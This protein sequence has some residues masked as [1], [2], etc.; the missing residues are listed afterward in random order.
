LNTAYIGLGS[1]MGDRSYFLN[2][3]IK[4]L[5]SNERISVI[6]TS[7]IYETAPVG[8]L[9]QE[10]FL[11]MVIKVSTILKPIELLEV[12]Q[13]VEKDLGR[14]RDIRWGPRTID[15]DILMYNNENIETEKLIIPHPRM[16]ERAFVLVPLMEIDD[17][18]E[19]PYTKMPISLFIKELQDREEV[20]IWKRKSGEGV[21]ELFEN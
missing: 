6:A 18:I 5:D 9:E 1:N 12:N 20:Q 14:K 7:S 8:Y 3:A 15:L 21:Y 19:I 4:S 17:T 11:N 16:K 13:Q 2:E 10:S